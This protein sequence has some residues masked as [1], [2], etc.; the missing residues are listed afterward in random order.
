MVLRGLLISFVALFLY[1]CTSTPMSQEGKTIEPQLSAFIADMWRMN[2]RISFVNEQENW[3]A[4]FSWIQQKQDFQIS[5][6]GPLGKT[7]LQISQINNR[8]LLKTPSGET[9]SDNL[10]QLLLQETG[11]KFTVTSLRYWSQGYPDPDI[12]SQVK[13]NELQQ[14]S[15]IFQAG[16]H[17]QYP[18]RMQVEQ[19]SGSYLTLPKKI[20]ATEQN[21]KIKLIITNWHL[22]ESS[23]ELY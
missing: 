12:A 19:L 3:Y 14:I 6:T 23:T 17:I 15:D 21:V 8:I 11:W 13:Y 2:G 22:G 10:E 9:S 16:W 4:K 7:E 5:F 20:I 18:K 1:A